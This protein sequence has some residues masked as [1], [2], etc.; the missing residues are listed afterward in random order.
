M[1]DQR[2]SE[3][4]LYDYLRANYRS[5]SFGI[6]VLS[7][8]R[9]GIYIAIAYFVGWVAGPIVMPVV[10]AIVVVAIYA[11]IFIILLKR[12]SVRRGLQELE[13]DPRPREVSD[14]A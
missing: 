9:A 6:F 7:A 8:V 3:E 11:D 10:V 12:R 14:R 5:F 4:S 2:F 1:E 13:H